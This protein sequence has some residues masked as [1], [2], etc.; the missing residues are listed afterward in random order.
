VL[1]NGNELW[2]KTATGPNVTNTPLGIQLDSDGNPYVL[3]N[4]ATASHTQQAVIDKFN[5]PGDV[6]ASFGPPAIGYA[7]IFHV[8]AKG[9]SYLA[10]SNASD[11]ASVVVKFTLTGSTAWIHSLSAA[12]LPIEV[13]S[14]IT[15]DPSGQVFLAQT[16]TDPTPNNG[17]DI[18]VLSLDTNGNER[19]LARYAHPNRSGQDMAV[20]LTVNSAGEPY[21]AGFVQVS[22]ETQVATVKLESTGK[23]ARARLYPNTPGGD[24]A[25]AIAGAG[26]NLFLLASMSNTSTGAG[27]TSIIDYVQDAAEVSPSSLTFASQPE[28]TQSAPQSFT[29]TNTTEVEMTQISFDVTGDFHVINNCPTSLAPGASCK[30][31]V[32]FTPTTTGTRSGTITVDD[33]WA[34]SSANPQTVKLTGTGVS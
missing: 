16:N 14:A 23:L 15:T 22:G 33:D 11:T 13:A 21:A 24:Q 2:S 3:V 10:G 8:D 7:P 27:G 18:S 30:V 29:L 6:L 4:S 20:A 26:S 1:I 25:Q 32:T 19:W 5:P 28:K 9:N 17:D 12:V 34:G 31:G